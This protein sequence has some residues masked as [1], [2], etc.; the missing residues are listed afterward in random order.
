MSQAVLEETK[1]FY[2]EQLL[3][4]AAQAQAIAAMDEEKKRSVSEREH[5]V[6]YVPETIPNVMDFKQIKG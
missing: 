4:K 3:R 1:A 2:Q 6:D 5:W